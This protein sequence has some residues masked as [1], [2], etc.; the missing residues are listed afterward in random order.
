MT[1]L[2]ER[3]LRNYLAKKSLVIAAEREVNESRTHHRFETSWLNKL[4]HSAMIDMLVVLDKEAKEALDFYREQFHA[5]Y[6][7][8]EP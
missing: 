7:Q 1:E 8:T 4:H 2:T 5:E 6:I 3:Y